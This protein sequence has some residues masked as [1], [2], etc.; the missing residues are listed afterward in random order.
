MNISY[1]LHCER[2]VSESE[3][4]SLLVRI[5]MPMPNMHA[6]KITVSSVRI[7][8]GNPEK[9]ARIVRTPRRISMLGLDIGIVYRR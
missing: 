9:G 3:N 2:Q 7:E 8:T 5:D 6:P 1:P 4:Y